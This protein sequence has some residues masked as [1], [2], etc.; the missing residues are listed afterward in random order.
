MTYSLPLSAIVATAFLFT[1]KTEPS[2]V[3]TIQKPLMI[4]QERKTPA[5]LAYKQIQVFEKNN[6]NKEIES[7]VA[8]TKFLSTQ[9]IAPEE[10]KIQLSEMKF[11][12]NEFFGSSSEARKI[13]SLRNAE[14]ENI[15]TSIYEKTFKYLNPTASKASD[16]QSEYLE[17][18][19]NEDPNFKKWATI[20]GK[21]ELIEGVGIVDHVI[22]FKRIEEGRVREVGAVDLNAGLYSIDIESP[23]GYL[24]AQIKDR[25]GRVVGED[26]E[27]IINLQGRSGFFEG[28]FLQVGRPPSVGLNPNI[29]NNQRSAAT[30]TLKASPFSKTSSDQSGAQVAATVFDNQKSFEY[31]GDWISNTSYNTSTIARAYDPS[32]FYKNITS[33]RHARDTS[34]TI[35]FTTNWVQGVQ[36][37]F[38]DYHGSPILNKEAPIIIGRVMIDGKPVSGAEVQIVSALGE[39]PI[40]FNTL[41][42]PDFSAQSTSE[43]GFFMFQGLPE[44]EYIVSAI[45]NNSY[46]GSELFMAENQSVAYQN[47]LSTEAPISK[48]V[49]SYDAFNS[50]IQEVQIVTADLDGAIDTLEGSAQI[51]S[52]TQ[53]GVA[54]YLVQPQSNDYLPIRFLQSSGLDYVHIPLLQ[55]KWLE[56]IK[57]MKWIAQS[58]S[59]GIVVGFTTELDYDAYLVDE[60]Y[61]SQNLVYFDS[62]GNVV[63]TPVRGGG[64]VLFNVPAGVKEL[65]LQEK[66]TDRIFSQVIPVKAEQISVTSFSSEL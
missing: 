63:S 54:E 44:G 11:A 25:Y 32:G 16:Y 49:R 15:D 5:F 31:A 34:E 47:I 66:E 52:Q 33:I 36:Q 57:A 28:P 27:R 41:M 30:S 14:S 19:K 18:T 60:S 42:A 65:V 22:E 6:I 43:N 24:I 39:K 56:N 9:K 2:R 55:E 38:A 12:K 4:T 45:K 17:S 21:L 50:N 61:S 59:K 62:F 13:A 51:K 20:R 7:N 58:P 10:S 40:Y 8:T 53:F 23:K 37:F 64:F 46:I 3:V 35:M 48:I 1:T 26:R 29:L